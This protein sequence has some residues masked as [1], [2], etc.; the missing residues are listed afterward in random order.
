MTEDEN[1]RS[2]SRVKDKP[3]ITKDTLIKDITSKG[4]ETVE[5]LMKRGLHC[6]G[7]PMTSQETLEQGCKA[8]G[9]SDEQIDELV[10]EINEAVGEKEKSKK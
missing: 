5:L 7:C 1:N 6:I 4:P 3:K 2:Q 10:K 9:M 8:H